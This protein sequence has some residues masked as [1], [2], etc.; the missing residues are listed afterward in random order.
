MNIEVGYFPKR[1]YDSNPDAGGFFPF[2][3][4]GT[5]P[6]VFSM[7]DLYQPL[8]YGEF[9]SLWMTNIK[10]F[11]LYFCVEV[12]S[13]WIDDVEHACKKFDINYKYLIKRYQRSVIITEIQNKKQLQE[14]FPIYFSIGCENELVLWSTKK[15]VFSIEQREW[16]GNWEGEVKRTVVVTVEAE[17]SVFWIGYDGT[18]I[19]VISNQSRF[20]TYE[21]IF[22]AFP[23][24]VVP[25]I[26]EFE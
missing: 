26:C 8:S 22:E 24:F 9:L 1:Y 21:R 16:K 12:P 18:N 6:Y 4:E 5:T 14:I 20:S 3:L 13:Y 10:A 19:A 17:T 23:E 15:D 11:P 2:A 25:K 7:G